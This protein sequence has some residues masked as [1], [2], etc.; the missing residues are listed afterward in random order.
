[1]RVVG[2]FAG[3]QT[4]TSSRT[5]SV[6]V[7]KEGGEVRV[8]GAV[9]TFTEGQTADVCSWMQTSA[10]TR[11]SLGWRPQ[12]PE[13]LTDMRDSGYFADMNRLAARG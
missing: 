7:V 11:K 4:L 1:V 9:A 10:L 13:L 6:L 5:S 2:S 3:R 12:E 8:V